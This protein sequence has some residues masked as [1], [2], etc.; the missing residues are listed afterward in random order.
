M[1]G[2][3]V[4]A[5]FEMQFPLGGIR[6]L[7]QQVALLR[8][9]GV[10]AYRWTPTPG[11]RYTWFD[12]DVPTLS[13]MT[14]ELD[15]DDVLLLPE[16]AVAPDYDPAPGGHTVIY[17]QGHYITFLGTADVEPYPGWAT[18]PALWTVSQA[19][20]HM[21]R[22][23]LP[24]FEPHL[25]PNVI[26]AELFRP[27]AERIRRVAWMSRKR[28][29]ESTLLR[30]LLRSD[31]RSQGVELHD[32]NGVSHEEVARVLGETSV[33]IA[34]GSPE[35]EGFGLPA[36]EAMAAGCLVT[37][38]T[39]GGGAELFDSPSAWPIAELAT[40]ELA[41]KALELLDRPDQDDVRRAGRQWV[42]D[43]YNTKTATDALVEGVRLARAMPGGAAT[44]THPA[45][46]LAEIV[47]HFPKQPEPVAGS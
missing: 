5:S 17:S 36:A 45:R 18:R 28:P 43:R 6:V 27:G 29:M 32:I 14:L 24:G 20:V 10:E 13:G 19:G 46:W 12:D 3:V 42:Q 38:Y 16:V 4:Y 22:R 21:L 39:G 23:A 26:D 40:D 7:S 47:K 33:F 1:A 44:A 34:L 8:A 30:R 35:G 31:P 25:V 37:G 2:R 15:Q 9:A 11:F 41:D